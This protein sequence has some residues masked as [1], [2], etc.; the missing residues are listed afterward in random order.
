MGAIKKHKRSLASGEQRTYI[1]E[2][3][4]SKRRSLGIVNSSDSGSVSPKLYRTKEKN[5]IV[6]AL[7][8]NVSL[9]VIGEQ[10][11]GKSVLLDFVT[12]DLETIGFQVV[13][14]RS[15]TT[16]VALLRIARQLGIETLSLSGKVLKVEELQE[17]IAEFLSENTVFLIV[18]NAHKLQPSMHYWLE[19]LHDQKQPMLLSA[20]HPPARDI[21]LKLPRI[22]LQPLSD[23]QIREI[24]KEAAAARG[25]ELTNAQL[26]YLQQRCGGNPMLAERVI[27]EEYAGLDETNPDHTQ[28]VD[29]TPYLIA[30]LTLFVIVRFIGLGFNSTSLYLIGAIL[31]V[32]VAAI[33]VLFHSLPRKSGRL[34]H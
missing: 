34:G 6:A 31:T 29:G 18:D 5:R 19:E 1:Y 12:K 17:A 24:M 28:W 16:K 8:A 21:F 15:S 14:V 22:E 3:N 30:G 10:G 7:Q 9:L 2:V 23:L 33:K 20:R 32:F 4:G 13:V 25:I 11:C 27:T 26:A